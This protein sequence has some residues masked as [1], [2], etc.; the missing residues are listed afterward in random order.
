MLN[1]AA[2]YY[3][4][5]RDNSDYRKLYLG[6]V[7]SLLGD[8]F[9]YVAVQT[10]VFELTNSGLAAG[11]ALI[12]STLP[13]FFLT[14]L[15]GAIVD[16]F[17]RRKIMIVA[18]VSRALIALGMILVSTA[19][20]IWLIYV[21]MALLVVFGSFFNPASSAAIPNLVRRDELYTANA[22]SNSTWGAMLA[23]GALVGGI[24]IATV[25]KDMAFV[26]NSLSFLFSAAMLWLIRRPFG[27]DHAARHLPLNPFADFKEGFDYAIRRPQ[28]LSLLMVKAGGSLA[29]GV[30]LLLTVFSFSVFKMGEIGIG[31]LGM[32]RG[33]GILAGPLLVAPLVA[34][35]ISRAQWVIVCGFLLAGTG[36][37]LF[38]LTSSLV[39][40][41][42]V[43]VMAHVGWGSNWSLSATII[44]R[45]TPDQVRGRIFSMDIGLFTLANASSTFLTGIATDRY[46]AHLVSITLGLVF[47]AFG[48]CWGT[49]I[50]LGQRT[51]PQ[52]WVDGDMQGMDRVEEGWVLD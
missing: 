40:G 51:Q 33:I 2:G 23:V 3:Q 14:P 7:V 20:Q 4:I 35:R 18:D 41:M 28:L 29:G 47:I 15:A 10:I 39:L 43:V 8:W 9:N 34:G 27:E 19:D 22:L 11:L 12:T 36:Y 1:V 48:A 49:G 25:G 37:F 16:R 13:A 17:D 45:L 50:W 24:A 5:L 6:Q 26:I 31:L 38:G 30:I 52:R 32:A 46:D 44:Q 21:L 42:L